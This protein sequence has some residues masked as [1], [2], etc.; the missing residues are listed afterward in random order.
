MERRKETRNEKF[1]RLAEKRMSKLFVDMNKIANLAVNSRYE[2]TLADIQEL[3]E[4]YHTEGLAMRAYF[5]SP[6][7]L[8]NELPT[9]FVFE[10]TEPA[11][12]AKKHTLFRELAAKRMET[13]FLDARLIVNLS[14][15]SNYTYSPQEVDLLMDGYDAKGTEIYNRFIPLKERFSFDR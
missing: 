14:N 3:F 2:A 10:N 13:V 1:H 5:D 7:T 11:V 9:R 4:K 12:D 8:W 15:K 6:M